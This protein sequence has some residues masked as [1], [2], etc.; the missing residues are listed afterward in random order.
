MLSSPPRELGSHLALA[1][2]CTLRDMTGARFLEDLSVGETKT[3]GRVSV[4]ATDIIEFAK[5]YDPQPMHMD[6]SGSDSFGGL[7][8]SGWHTAALVMRLLADSRLLGSTPLL[9]LGVDDLR[10]PKPVRPG[11]TIQAETETLSIRRSQ[12]Q[13]CYG[14]V[15]MRVTARNQYG[16]VVYVMTTNL[17]VPSRNP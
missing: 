16:D 5:G 4:S 13:P 1:L 17:W 9:G 6:P 14:V 11:D 2:Y 15:R 8:A 3:T 10:W 7:I 12:S